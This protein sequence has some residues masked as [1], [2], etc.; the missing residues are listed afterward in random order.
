MTATMVAGEHVAGHHP[1]APRPAGRWIDVGLDIAT[2]VVD[3]LLDRPPACDLEQTEA[4]AGKLVAETAIL[5][6]A[7]RDDA[8]RR[9]RV[10]S[11]AARL[12]PH[13][14]NGAVRTGVAMHP[15][16]ALD[17]AAGYLA[18]R[19]FTVDDRLDALLHDALA[20]PTATSR[21]RV[22]HRVLEQH[23]LRSLLDDA[24]RDGDDAAVD[25]TVPGSELDVLH[26]TRDDGYAFT[27]ALMYATDFGHRPGPTA[28]ATAH[29]LGAR[30]ASAVARFLDDDDFDLVG[31][32]LLTWPLLGLP[33]PAVGRFAYCVLDHAAT[34]VGLLPS[35]A[36][37]AAAIAAQPPEARTAYTIAVSYH[38][39][40]VMA[41]A[42]HVT[43]APAPTTPGHDPAMAAALDV[44]IGA[45]PGRVPEW[46]REPA[47]AV[48]AEL[49]VDV[50]LIRAVRRS[51]LATAHRTLVTAADAGIA[52][53][54]AMCQTTRLLRRAAHHPVPVTEAG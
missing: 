35:A 27:H 29:D 33:L 30:A 38:S 47:T 54:T 51:D 50:A 45:D 16:L 23:W 37:S 4:T 19:A 10:E 1:A 48:P 5:L 2:A 17:Y 9:T 22:P 13:A 52:T 34:T 40:Y 49:L 14:T 41:L 46:R 11:L 6:H 7:L 31:E 53:T 8:A 43:G 24:S 39:A 36:M 3:H 26:G 20:D 44:L 28:T 12:V 21:E 18:L 15:A 25:A 42:E 32:L